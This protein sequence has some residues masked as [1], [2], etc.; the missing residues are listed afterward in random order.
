MVREQRVDCP[1]GSRREAPSVVGS[2]V[3]PAGLPT[4]SCLPCSLPASLE[5]KGRLGLCS[6]PLASCLRAVLLSGNPNHIFN[7]GAAFLPEA[8][9]ETSLRSIQHL[10]SQ[11]DRIP[12]EPPA[13]ASWGPSGGVDSRPRDIPLSSDVP[14]P[15]RQ[16][17]LLGGLFLTEQSLLWVELCLPK[18]SHVEV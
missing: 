17:I 12:S 8:V 2:G 9:T 16:H 13:P 7:P 4:A 11:H 15:A 5:G 3:L 14:A 18:H 6:L 1:F 10:Q